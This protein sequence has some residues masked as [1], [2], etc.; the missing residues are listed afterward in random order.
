MAGR[1]SRFVSEP[2]TALRQAYAEG[3]AKSERADSLYDR[4]LEFDDGTVWFPDGKP[5]SQAGRAGPAAMFG[6]TLM[7]GTT[8]LVLFVDGHP[9]AVPSLVGLA[10]CVA[11]LALLLVR[12]IRAEA[13]AEARLERGVVLL[14]DVLVL[15]DPP[16][17]ERV[18]RAAIRAFEVKLARRGG[19]KA[20][21]WVHVARDG[22]A[23][24]P[25]ALTEASLATLR[26]WLSRAP[27]P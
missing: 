3:R 19:D 7:A 9:W 10:L 12:G 1:Y 8:S 15:R 21:R 24:I 22:G 23:E 6:L 14:E 13:A 20:L 4:C 25:L 16:H 18:P 17:D 27:P 26:R 5:D 2:W 11:G